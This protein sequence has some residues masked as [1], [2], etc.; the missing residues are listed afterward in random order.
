MMLFL[1]LTVFGVPQGF[2][3]EVDFA[4]RLRSAG[5]YRIAEAHCVQLLARDD[6][7]PEQRVDVTVELSKTLVAWGLNSRSPE[8]SKLWT[9]TFT[10]IQ[11][12]KRRA[13]E[14]GQGRLV[15]RLRGVLPL[16][17]RARLPR[18]RRPLRDQPALEL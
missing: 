11:D 1:L 7:S 14:P 3:H 6:L 16:G 12:E 2:D 15:P 9:R 5:L 4:S 8:Q 17:V 10:L 13:R 18:R